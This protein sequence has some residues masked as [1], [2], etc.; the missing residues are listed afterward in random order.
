LRKIAKNERATLKHLARLESRVESHATG[1]S[2]EDE[3]RQIFNHAFNIVSR[4]EQK[5]IEQIS[6]VYISD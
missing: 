5:Q 6:R 2:G 3:L 4:A 1:T